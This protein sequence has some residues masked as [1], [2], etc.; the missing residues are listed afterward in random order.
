MQNVEGEAKVGVDDLFGVGAGA[1]GSWSSEE[2]G[3][4]ENVHVYQHGCDATLPM[5]RSSFTIDEAAK[6]ARDIKGSDP[7]SCPGN[8]QIALLRHYRQVEQFHDQT[9]NG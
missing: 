2:Y 8:R 7:S 1:A 4:V 5:M 9:P 6:Y 3:D